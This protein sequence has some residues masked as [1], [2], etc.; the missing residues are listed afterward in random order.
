[1]R[2]FLI[3]LI[4]LLLQGCLYFNDRGIS[5]N[6]YSKCHHSYDAHGK[7]IKICDEN[8]VDYNE[9]AVNKVEN[10]SNHSQNI[11]IIND[12]QNNNTSCQ[13]GVLIDE[14]RG[15]SSR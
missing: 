12:I 3:L 2:Y 6:L 8:I 4:T 5:G 10:N 15:C 9:S 7:Y 14:D 11:V 1:M 13:Q